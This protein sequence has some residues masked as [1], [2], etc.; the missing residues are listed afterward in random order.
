MASQP[1]TTL[2][3]LY[4]QRRTSDLRSFQKTSYKVCKLAV[5]SSILS[6]SPV[7]SSQLSH[8]VSIIPDEPDDSFQSY[9]LSSMIESSYLVQNCD[10]NHANACFSI[11]NWLKSGRQAQA[12]FSVDAKIS[13][14]PSC[15]LSSNVQ[16]DLVWFRDSRENE[17]VC[18]MEVMSDGDRLK[19]IL[20]LGLD[21]MKQLRFLRNRNDA[22]TSVKGFYFPLGAGYVEEAT[23]TWEDKKMSF[24]LTSDV[25]HPDAVRDRIWQIGEEQLRQLAS[26][27]GCPCKGLN[28]PCSQNFLST[29]FGNGSIQLP[30]GES[31]VVLNEN[32][33]RVYKNAFGKRESDQLMF[34]LYMNRQEVQSQL[35][36]MP[37]EVEFHYGLSFF[38]FKALLPPPTVSQAKSCIKHFTKLVK[39]SLEEFHRI[40]GCAH[41]DVCIDNVCFCQQTDGSLVAVLVDLD[42]A[43]EVTDP[44]SSVCIYGKECAM[45]LTDNLQRLDQVDWRQLAIM[46]L[47]I[48][49]LTKEDHSPQSF[50]CE[51]VRKLY[52][53][54][55]FLHV[56]FFMLCF[57]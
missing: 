38:V 47:K 36:S 57:M 34:F 2:E 56:Q 43:L 16:P 39:E 9:T 17:V 13:N 3:S 52:H 54:G 41:L 20:K 23:L 40:T 55:E 33:D 51:F 19:T 15:Y 7:A 50:S 25:L 10:T 24:Y 46:I 18:I 4:Q 44:L 29:E 27:D 5:A 48:L 35:I 37:I 12:N 1:I 32:R 45:Y 22:I 42:R 53:E 21:M 28:L 14:P 30:S 6:Q 49:G 11:K 31:L 8:I 26:V